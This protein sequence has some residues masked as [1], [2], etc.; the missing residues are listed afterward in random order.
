MPEDG[1][2]RKMQKLLR[3]YIAEQFPGHYR[4]AG[5]QRQCLGIRPHPQR[6]SALDEILLHYRKLFGTS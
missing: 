3:F 2:L 5:R 1:T 4:G 6:I